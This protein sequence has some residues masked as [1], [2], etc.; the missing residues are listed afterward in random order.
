MKFPIQRVISGVVAVLICICAIN[1]R[2]Q[3]TAFTYQGQLS[4]SGAAATGIYDLQFTLR[5]ASSAGNAVGNSVT[6]PAVAVSNGLFTV[7]LDFGNAFDGNARWLELGVRTNGSTSAYTLLSPRQPIT[8]TPYAIEAAS[9]GSVAASGITGQVTYSQLPGTLLTNGSSSV[10]LNGNFGGNASGLTNLPTTNLTGTL[11]DNQLGTNVAR[12]MIANTAVQATGTPVVTSGFITSATVINAGAG[13]IATPTVTV[14]D[15]TGSNAV[16]TAT[17]SGG[18]VTALTV[19]NPGT[20]Y[21]AGA[22][23]TINA[24]P[25]NGYQVFGSANIFNGINTFSNAGNT[26]VGDGG[27]LTALKAASLT[28]AGSLPASVLPANVALL[29]ANQTFTGVNV[30][31]NNVGVG[32]SLPFRNFQ[33]RPAANRV[34]SV[35]GGSQ[36]GGIGIESVNDANTVNQL[37]EFRGTPYVFSIGNVAIGTGN[38]TEKLEVAGTD[39]VNSVGCSIRV[40]NL[41]DPVGGFIGDAYNSIQ[42]GMYNPSAGTVGVMTA[43]TKRS[44]FGFD[45]NGKVGSLINAFGSPTYRNVLDDG[46]GNMSLSG[47]LSLSGTTA[48]SGI[49]YAGG[50]P[51]IHSFG[52]FNFFAGS[53]AGNLATTGFR[54]TGVGVI[55]LVN[56]TS[57]AYNSAI[58]YASLYAN[59]SG[60]ANAANGC[61]ALFSNVS[62]NNNTASGFGALY[63]NIS[64]SDNCAYGF[65]ALFSS[66]TASH[67]TASGVFAL[68]ASVSGTDNTATGWH[69][70]QSSTNANYNTATGSQALYNNL[71]GDANAATGFQTMYYNKT[72]FY[73]SAHGSHALYQNVGGYQNAGFG[74]DAL[75]SNVNGYNNTA[76]GFR[77]LFNN[78]ANYNTAVGYQALYSNTTGTNNVAVGNG[79]GINLTVGNNN[80]EIA[81]AGTAGENGVVHIGTPGVHTGTFIAGVMN[82]NGFGLTNLSPANI[83]AG[84]ANISIT[85]NAATATTAGI[86]TAYSGTVAD[87]QLSTNIPHLDGTNNFSG[88]NIFTDTIVALNTNNVIS[89]SFSGNGAGLQNLSANAVSGGLTTN[90]LV[91]APGGGTN[92]LCFTNGILRAIQ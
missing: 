19:Q 11:T 47:N 7:K 60:G 21:S 43:G 86:A 63:S 90:L 25:S 67:N 33:V 14:N 57:G 75:A 82:G 40:R 2:S 16:I 17:V 44:F 34:F 66:T 88:T 37:M 4:D 22:T 70:L 9:A 50:S 80:V 68:Y 89:G 42:L 27:G 69:A 35:Y 15:S 76:A 91:L 52:S 59:T 48:S 73:N 13:Y 45:L 92:T 83:L 53:Q 28:G 61:E 20:H 26:F 72:G 24:P 55:A 62:G 71:S 84:T 31:G 8:S 1:V 32:I 38:T 46:A 64:G 5:D 39:T 18:A 36:G 41:S 30:F 10:V 87:S 6:N 23:L 81:N 65:E 51:L 3:S 74:Y 85:G 12:L 78:T 56:N 49:V 58:G 77:S 54:D 29:D 79:A